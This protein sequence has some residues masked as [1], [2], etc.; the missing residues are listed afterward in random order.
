MVGAVL[1]ARSAIAK[2]PSPKV[3]PMFIPIFREG[4]RRRE[5]GDGPEML[6]LDTLRARIGECAPRAMERPRPEVMERIDAPHPSSRNWRDA[7]GLSR[8]G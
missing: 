6:D 8:S 3:P 1:D 4:G 5:D 2:D 7:L